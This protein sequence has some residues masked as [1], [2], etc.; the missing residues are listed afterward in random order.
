MTK[1]LFWDN[2]GVLVD[3]EY[4]Y[5]RATQRA[6]GELGVELTES[7]Y[8]TFMSKGKPCWDLASDVGFGTPELEKKRSDRN[9]YYQNYLRSEDIEIP[10]VVEVLRALS[11]TYTMAIVTTSRCEDF[12]LIH[13]HRSILPLMDFVI[14]REDYTKSKPDPEP[15]LAALKKF[16]ARASD[17]IVIEDSQRGLQ[18]A[19]AAGIE[20]V[21]VHNEFTK[22]HDFTGATHSIQAL[23]E[24]P[25]LLRGRRL[26]TI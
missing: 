21:V 12:D 15:Y 17:A 6:L 2:D 10:G 5:F 23:W 8:L 11:E 20:C 13:Q 16:D 4:W 14:T 7:T 25:E 26:L 3:T 22:T 18:S 19:V 24:L 9:S 1:Y